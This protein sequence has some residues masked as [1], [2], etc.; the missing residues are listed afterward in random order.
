[1]FVDDV[2]ELDDGKPH[3][4]EIVKRHAH[5]SFVWPAIVSA[6]GRGRGAVGVG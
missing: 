3:V 5:R 4:A 6:A 1:V 2:V